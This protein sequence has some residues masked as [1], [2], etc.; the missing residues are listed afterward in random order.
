MLEKPQAIA[1]GIDNVPK[2]AIGILLGVLLF[3]TFV[4]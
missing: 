1:K 3:G 4:V 2:I